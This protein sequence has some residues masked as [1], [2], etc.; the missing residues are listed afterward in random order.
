MPFATLPNARL[1]YE[2]EGP[3]SA[4]VIVF[5]H[6]LGATLAMWGRQAAAF[7]DRFRVLRYDTRGH[8]QSSS[9]PGPY[10]IEGL[11]GD[12]LSLLDSLKID[13]VHFCGLSMGGQTGQWLALNAPHRL[14]K[15]VLCNTG[16]KIGIAENWNARI[17]AVTKAGMKEIANSVVARWFSPTFH[18]L[19][20]ED[21]APCL[22]AL[23]AA[24]PLGYV[25]CCA[26]VRDYDVRDSVS[27][28]RIPTLVITG[29]HD[30]ATPPSDGRYLAEQIPG[31]RYAE[32][33]AG[34]L[35]CIEDVARFNAE[36]TAFLAS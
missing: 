2:L 26:A 14:N 30:V 33:N 32:L 12:V 5:S 10:D 25:A 31:A 13:R 27:K 15:L 9:P 11:A 19:H 4:P 23:E 36:L 16:A 8:G 28:I 17:D 34:H 21:V 7:S 1:H 24:V 6:S 18:E 29:A 35:S 20:S 3:Q 22:S